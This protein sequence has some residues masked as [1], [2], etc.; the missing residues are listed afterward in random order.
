MNQKGVVER[1]LTLKEAYYVFQSYWTTAPMAHLYGHFWPVRWGTPD[2]Q[3]L[4][5]VYSNC[6]QAELFVNGKSYGVKKRNS[7]DFPAAGLHWTVPFAT[8][9][10]HLRVVARQGRQT[11]QDT[12]SFRYQTQTWTKPA[13]LT[14][15]KVAEANGRITVAA[16]LFDAQGVPCLDAANWLEFSLAGAGQLLDDLGIS[17]GSRKV[18]AYNGRALISLEAKPGQSAV[19]V[20]SLGLT[21]AVLAL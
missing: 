18:Q 19:A 16:Q 7:Q 21:T 14:L 6:E 1:D 15:T 5:K 2:E 11:V 9:P 8:G 13:R 12:L 20:Q 17:R 10:N 4:V 3:K